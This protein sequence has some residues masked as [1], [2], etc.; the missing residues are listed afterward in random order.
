MIININVG[1]HNEK[2]AH[3]RLEFIAFSRGISFTWPA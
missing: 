2:T 3:I 1:K